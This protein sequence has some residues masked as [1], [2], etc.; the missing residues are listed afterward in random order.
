MKNSVLTFHLFSLSDVGT[1]QSNMKAIP[2][3]LL[4]IALA[5]FRTV[6]GLGGSEEKFIKKY[7]MMKVYE[8][9]FGPQVLREI[10]KEMRE[11]AQKCSGEQVQP[12][13]GKQPLQFLRN[14]CNSMAVQN[15]LFFF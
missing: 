7:A 6:S 14:T 1:E 9:C 3:Y 8:S 11:A 10:R 15:I 12:E 4:L 5:C 2:T 13:A